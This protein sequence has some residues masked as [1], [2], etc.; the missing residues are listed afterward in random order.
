[1]KLYEMT[2]HELSG[3]LR[4]K[5]ISLTELIDVFLDRIEEIDDIIGSYISVLPDDAPSTP[6]CC[7]NHQVCGMLLWQAFHRR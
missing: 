1:M 6:R 2:A 5:E 4:G 7:K 3:L